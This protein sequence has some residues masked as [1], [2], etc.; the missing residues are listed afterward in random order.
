MLIG[1]VIGISVMLVLF[2]CVYIA[3]K[4]TRP[5]KVLQDKDELESLR[6]RDEGIKNIMEYDINVAMGKKVSK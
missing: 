5:K 3:Y 4:L 6:K 2:L 1:I